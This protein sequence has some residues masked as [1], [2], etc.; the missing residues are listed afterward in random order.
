PDPV[1]EG[2][3][4][5]A[6]RPTDNQTGIIGKIKSIEEVPA[7]ETSPAMYAIVC[8]TKFIE[9][10]LAHMDERIA[11]VD[12]QL[13]QALERKSVFQQEM[14][15]HQQGL[16]A[17]LK[18]IQDLE[19]KL[20]VLEAQKNDVELETGK[21][22]GEMDLITAEFAQVESGLAS[23]KVQEGQLNEALSGIAG[24]VRRCQEDIKAK[25]DAVV[26]KN[27]EREELSMAV[28]QLEAQVQS[29]VEKQKSFE[30]NRM[31]YTQGLDRDLADVSRFDQEA[32]EMLAKKA[33]IGE[34]IARL[35]RL[36]QEA[37]GSLKELAAQLE[38]QG[39]RK[40]ELVAVLNGLRHQTRAMEEEII[41]VKTQ[42]HNQDMRR[43]E[44]L[45][46]QRSLKERL[47]QTY[48]IDW[49]QLPLPGESSEQAPVNYEELA[50]EIERLKKRCESYGAV[51]LVAIEEHEELKQRFEF[52]TKQQSDLLTAR[53]SLMR[54]IQ[55]INRTTRKM[56]T[57]TFAR[58]NEEFQVHFRMLFGGGEA[59][60]ILLD[61]ENA[62]ECG[63][64]IMARPPG[65]KPQHISLLSGGEKTLTAIALIFGVFK[66]NPSPF[67]VLDEIDA[68]LDESNVGRF[69][70]LLKEFAQIAQFIVITHNKKTMENADILYGVTM[71]ER[72]VS[73]IMSVR[74]NQ[75][76][77]IASPKTI[78]SVEPQPAVAGV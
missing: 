19:K 31:V 46:N 8:A 63:I 28:V 47:L 36:A 50:A 76:A 59:Q 68:A 11:S 35:G 58:V 40:G 65:K 5:S 4:L 7:A 32:L 73:R 62:L 29:A 74:F 30:E 54:T 12:V 43:Q 10:D 60:L 16:D 9:L 48:K 38:G 2:R 3:F 21:I 33:A 15:A 64:D 51:N 13:I 44:V 23:L 66:V 56:F 42:R 34:D 55:D 37:D 49:D 18:R 70:H 57:E 20:S 71:P 75:G 77:A 72:G 14:Q 17:V 41:A 25:Q 1:V 24:Q 27:K 69:A 45:F 6:A 26:L 53:E 78:I 67:C 61:P 22:T 39:A 52:L